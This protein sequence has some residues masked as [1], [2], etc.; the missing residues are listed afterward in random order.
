[1]TDIVDKIK[2]QIPNHIL[3][4]Y[5][6]FVQFIVDY[7]SWY[8]E[9]DHP[10]YAI[11]K[12]MDRLNMVESYQQYVDALKYE[13]LNGL[14]SEVTSISDIMIRW[15]KKFHASRGSR[16]SYKLLFKILFGNM[17]I[18]FYNPKQDI[19]MLSQSE[20]IGDENL[21]VVDDVIDIQSGSTITFPYGQAFVDR[22]E[23]NG[24]G[25]MSIIFVEKTGDILLNDVVQSNG[26][27]LLALSDSIELA[28]VYSTTQSH[29][30]NTSK[31]ID[32]DYYDFY[33]YVI[34]T[35]NELDE[36]LD[37]IQNLLQPAGFKLIIE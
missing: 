6:R 37:I 9:S 19:F 26:N 20:Y 16:L 28:G 35:S 27:L 23:D 31:L 14:P 15:S 29:L 2:S 7:Y 22:T 4:T 1:M 3:Q 36:Y 11:K 25:T 21:V 8:L 34:R 5:P 30:S 13:Y 32:S 24:D 18:Q 33:T 10:R 17:D 12:H